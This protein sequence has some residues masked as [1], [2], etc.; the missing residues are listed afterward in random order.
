[1]KHLNLSLLII[2]ACICLSSNCRKSPAL[3]EFYIKCKID[4]QE[5]L[6][7][8]CANCMVGKLL[9][10]SVFLMNAN[11]GFESL[12]IGVNVADPIT[13]SYILDQKRGGNAQFDNSPLVDDIFKTDSNNKGSLNI[14]QINKADKIISGNFSFQAYNPVQNKL[15]TVTE[16]QF[17][18]HYSI[19]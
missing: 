10:D 2:I 5:Y 11:N 16:G 7:A 1:M 13:G 18:L 19:N 17:R 8:N 3:P 6:P 15:I 12:L 14:I 9:G 4:G